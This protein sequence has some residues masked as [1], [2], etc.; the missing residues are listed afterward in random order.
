MPVNSFLDK[1]VARILPASF[2]DE[3]AESRSILPKFETSYKSIKKS[4]EKMIWLLGC[5]FKGVAKFNPLFNRLIL[6]LLR[7]CHERR[8][9]YSK[10]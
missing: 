9:H 4:G 6:C 3:K 8:K 10:S 1:S 2:F 5:L 7:I